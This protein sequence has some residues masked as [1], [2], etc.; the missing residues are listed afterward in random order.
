MADLT[1]IVCVAF[2]HRSPTEGLREF[3]D[4][5][6]RCPFIESAM[7]VS[8]TFDLIVQARLA[9]LEEYTEQMERIADQLRVFVSRIESN[10]VGRKVDCRYSNGTSLWLPV[11]N[12]RK[13]VST[14]LIDKI[15]ANGDYINV[16][17]GEWTCMVHETMGRMVEQ[18]DPEQFIQ[19]H[20]SSLVRVGFIER[21]LH[22]DRRWI[23]RLRDGALQRVA[24]SRVPEL[25]RLMS[26]NPPK[27]RAD[28]AKQLEL[29]D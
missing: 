9:S 16:H 23:A 21:V 3:K 12:G 5:I 17:I 20:R 25:I 26:N 7:E 24:K 14:N 11:P 18:L 27:S 22:Q 8:G 6:F 2:D 13:Q 4:C 1:V 29:S 28:S 10:F 15:E 19:L